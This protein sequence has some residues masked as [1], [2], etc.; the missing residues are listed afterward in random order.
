[1]SDSYRITSVR[2]HIEE[3]E[4]D[5]PPMKTPDS[6][7]PRRSRGVV[8]AALLFGLFGGVLGGVA[9]VQL[10]P[11]PEVV[12]VTGD[13]TTATP[14]TTTEQ[15]LEVREDTAIIEA[16]KKIQPA[17]V[18]VI[19]TQERIDV[20]GRQFTSQGGGTGFVLTNDGLI[21]T[22]KHVVSQAN[23]EYSV[24]LASGETF[25]VTEVIEDPFADLA[26]VRIDATGLPIVELGDSDALQV[27]QKVI[28]IGN[29]LGAFENTV[30]SGIVSALDRSLGAG[31]QD[32]TLQGV[33][34][35]DTTINPGNSG[36][37]L[38]D[39]NG[40]VIGVNTAI[41][42]G[43]E[44]IGFAIPVNDTKIA[45]ESV[46]KNGRIVRPILGVRYLSVTPELQELSSLQTDRG[47]LLFSANR[48]TEPAIVP[49]GP[50]DEAG[51]VEGDIILSIEEQPLN[52]EHSVTRV[53]SRFAPGEEVNVE[54]LHEDGQ[55]EVLPLILGE[56][57]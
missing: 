18:S 2:E 30:T 28:A 7:K 43:G 54:V 19:A 9:V 55:T 46:L 49:G 25:E 32:E 45:F 10:T 37:P 4:R 38:L 17:V 21:L 22:N 33:I 56:S 40:R 52:E 12:I 15:V 29:A 36:G 6:A 8:F 3:E 34:Q 57:E 23:T 41:I 51:L 16:V 11:E 26:F 1:M 5:K 48:R 20:F 44:Q 27:G 42:Q 24:V 50:A 13:E 39:L 31:P 47:I 53:L 14:V 35:T